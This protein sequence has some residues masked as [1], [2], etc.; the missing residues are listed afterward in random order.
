[1]MTYRKA[2]WT[3]EYILSEA[4]IEDS[5]TDAWLLLE[6]ICKIDKAY[7]FLHKD[8]ELSAEEKQEYALVLAKRAERIPLQYI[9]GHQEFMGLKFQVNSNVLIPRQDTEL[10]VEHAL[11]MLTLEEKIL[12][13][14]TGTGCIAVSMAYYG[15]EKKVQV[16]ASDISKTVLL[17]AKENA[18]HNQVQVD[19]IRS[20]LFE[21]IT[22]KYTM[23]LTN[24]PYIPTKVIEELQPEVRNF[25][26]MI[27]LDGHDDG[28]HFYRRIAAEAGNYLEDEGHLLLEIGNDQTVVVSG[29]LKQAGFIDIEVKKDLSGHDRLIICRKKSNDEE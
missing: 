10:L 25:E 14:C 23:I 17:T 6:M 11:A 8:D 20:D 18:N 9:T 15:K 29:L 28:Y 21:K 22:E 26:P 12:D 7:Y 5:K 19:F 24:P 2:L 16:A 27:A 13:L 1:M 3:G 4:H